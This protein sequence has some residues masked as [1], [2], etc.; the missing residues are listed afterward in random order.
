MAS[1]VIALVHCS[2]DNINNETVLVH[3]S[4]GGDLMCR[5]Q[6]RYLALDVVHGHF[7]V[8]TEMVRKGSSI[9]QAAM[10]NGGLQD[11]PGAEGLQTVCERALLLKK[12]LNDIV[13]AGPG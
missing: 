10:V 8:G 7:R 6:L 2:A 9:I 4:R 11:F 12:Q 5:P 1:S 13:C 3:L